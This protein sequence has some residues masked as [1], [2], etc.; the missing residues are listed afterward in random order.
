M[1]VQYQSHTTLHPACKKPSGGLG[2]VCSE[3]QTCIRP[4]WCHCHSLSVALVKS[5]LVLP[6]WYRLTTTLHPSDGLFSRTVWVTRY[7]KGKTSL[8]LNEARDDGVLAWHM[9]TICASLQ[10]DNH[11][12]SSLNFYRLDAVANAQPT[13]S[14]HWRQCWVWCGL[15]NATVGG[16]GITYTLLSEFPAAAWVYV[17]FSALTVV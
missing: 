5:G 10:A 8:D 15:N 6:F 2:V 11:N 3:V 14:K 9:Q 12:T 16:H 4:S 13:V 17:S 1:C 7:Q